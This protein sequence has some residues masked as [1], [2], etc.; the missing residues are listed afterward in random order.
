[1]AGD[2]IVILGQI[3]NGSTILGTA[4]RSADG[5]TWETLPL[6]FPQGA[7]EIGVSLGGAVQTPSG[8]AVL[9]GV[10]VGGADSAPV[11]LAGAAGGLTPPAGSAEEGCE[12]G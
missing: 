7:G 12:A 4:W 1:M 11:H 10:V 9:G 6:G 5:S 2:N 8:L 3:G